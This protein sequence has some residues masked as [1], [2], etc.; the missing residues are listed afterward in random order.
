MQHELL[1]FHRRQD[2]VLEGAQPGHSLRLGL[3]VQLVDAVTRLDGE[4]V[5]VF[6]AGVHLRFD[7]LI[8]R[9]FSHKEELTERHLLTIRVSLI[10][11]YFDSCLA[12]VCYEIPLVILLAE[13]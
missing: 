10:L 3:T 7:I 9:E 1:H 12:K 4:T 5:L 11:A 8:G 2:E 6:P 13:K